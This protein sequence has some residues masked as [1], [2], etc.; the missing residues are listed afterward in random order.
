MRTKDIKI[1]LYLEGIE[2]K[3][4]TIQISERD[5][6]LYPTATI[7]LPVAP[8]GLAIHPRTLVHVFYK[9]EDKYYLIYARNTIGQEL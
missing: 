1:K 3:F 5:G 9:L 4:K 7:Y 2:I 6:A 8:E